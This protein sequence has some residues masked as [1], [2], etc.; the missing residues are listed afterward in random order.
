MGGPD[1]GFT[2]GRTDAPQASCPAVEP[3]LPRLPSSTA[4]GSQADNRFSPDGRLPDGDKGAQH[5][6]DIFYR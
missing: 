4:D 1:I 2:A 3:S 6:R 5:V